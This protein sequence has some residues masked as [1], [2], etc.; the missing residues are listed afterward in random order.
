MLYK[1]GRFFPDTSHPVTHNHLCKLLNGYHQERFLQEATLEGA[2]IAL[3]EAQDIL[4]EK[5]RGAKNPLF[6]KGN[7]NFG[8]M[9]G[10]TS[11]FFAQYGATFTKGSLCDGAG[12]AGILEGRGA[13]LLLP[14]YELQKSDVVIVWGRNPA[15]TNRHLYPLIQGK[16]VVVIDPVKT[17]SAKQAD[18]HLQ[19]KPHSDIYL[20]F[21]LSRFAHMEEMVDEA[22]IHEKCEDYQDYF[23]LT[24]S[25]PIKKLIA[26]CDIKIADVYELLALIKNKK[27]AI[28]LGV[29]VQKY[30][31]GAEIV[32]AIDSFAATLGLFGK[33]GSGVSFLGSSS[34][35]FVDPFDVVAKKCVDQAKVDFS[36]YDL[37]FIQGSNPAVT[38]P[39]T[40]KVLE[41][42]KRAGFVVYFGDADNAT[43]QQANL[44]IPT[45]NFVSKEDI[46]FSYFHEYVGR[47]PK[48]IESEQGISEYELADHL[49][50]QFNYTELKSEKE[51]IEQIV[52]SNATLHHEH[53]T[54]RT[55]QKR[56]YQDGFFTSSGKFQFLDEYDPEND[57]KEGYYLITGK[58]TGSLNSTFKPD[59][60][61]YI[62]PDN[63][64]KEGAR[65]IAK[66]SVGEHEFE[67][68]LNENLRIDTVMLHV[69]SKVNYLTKDETSYEGDNAIYQ[70]EKVEIRILG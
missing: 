10:A 44:V 51:Y 19:I 4:V 64:L 32:R 3:C 17:K 57:A 7:G 11:L 12:E 50:R 46:R 45:K 62:H 16:T 39:N 22:F 48:L 31:D 18:L 6:Y 63:G 36:Q 52:T 68:R 67:V 8:R 29:G 28:L 5:L 38:L 37:V 34:Y 30:I 26:A 14:S 56:P 23:D 70:N 69:G 42:L 61:L 66:S 60:Y 54:S 47:M 2:H 13:N 20:A 55:Y 43:A 58:S 21:L 24:R 27:T 15:V 49:C 35:G 40:Q 9:Q 65:V 59:P 53:L 25:Y 33:E 41:G 1:E